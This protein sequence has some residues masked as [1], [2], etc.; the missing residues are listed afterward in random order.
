MSRRM[1]LCSTSIPTLG[2]ATTKEEA[3]Q[4]LAKLAAIAAVGSLYEKRMGYSNNRGVE[5]LRDREKIG[6]DI[7][8]AESETGMEMPDADTLWE[9]GRE[10]AS[11]LLECPEFMKMV[12]SVAEV[13]SKSNGQAAM[14]G[15]RKAVE[16]YSNSAP[17][18]YR[19]NADIQL[20]PGCGVA[21]HRKQ[22]APQPPLAE[23][24][25]A[26]HRQDADAH[27]HTAPVEPGDGLVNGDY[28]R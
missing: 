20:G 21:D 17:L 1:A 10:K 27:V 4:A 22:A 7:Q 11:K 13:L 18:W 9:I 26:R 25:A 23:L 3:E 12:E 16:G 28:G 19:T 5:N 8:W 2:P 24:R 6:D 15:V 14:D